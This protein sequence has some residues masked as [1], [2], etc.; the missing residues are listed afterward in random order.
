MECPACQAS[1][2]K[3][4]VGWLCAGCGNLVEPAHH[5][6]VAKPTTETAPKPKLASPKPKSTT[7]LKVKVRT[8]RT[9]GTTSHIKPTSN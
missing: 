2:I 6:K 8:R 4:K 3:S 1:M 7:D 5:H 9:A